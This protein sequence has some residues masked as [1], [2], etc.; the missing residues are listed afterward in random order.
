[1]L[2]PR[3]ATCWWLTPVIPATQGSQILRDQEDRSSKPTQA[4]SSKDP[5]LKKKITKKKR[6][7][8]VAQGEGP[9]FKPIPHTHTHKGRLFRHSQDWISGVLPP[10]RRSHSEMDLTWHGLG[11]L[12]TMSGNVGRATHRHG[13]SLVRLTHLAPGKRGW[14]ASPQQPWTVAAPCGNF[15]SLLPQ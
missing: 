6:A 9:E 1:M 3:L 7:G 14:G 12:A 4:N 2:K 11:S 15:L 10:D 13:K 8:G 5:I